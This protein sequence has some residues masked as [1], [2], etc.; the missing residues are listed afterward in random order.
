[1][2]LKKII[3]AREP[4]ELTAYRSAVPKS[5]MEKPNIYEDYSDA[6]ILRK[7]LLSE[8]GYLLLLYE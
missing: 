4:K 7:Q 3:K 2:I 5:D 6:G 1:L 8:Q